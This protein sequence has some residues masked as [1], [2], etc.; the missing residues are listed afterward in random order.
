[1]I[2]PVT[3]RN[4]ATPRD[5]DIRLKRLHLDQ[6][7]VDR[8]FITD[9]LTNDKDASIARTIIT[10]GRNLDLTVIA[11]GVETN[12]QREFLEKQECHVYQGFLSSPAL[13][14]SQ[15]ETFIEASIAKE[16]TRTVKTSA[17]SVG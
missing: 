14:F 3:S 4:V 13:N 16:K 15:F 7:K 17:A 9:L 1:M 8:A 5:G 6:L 10:L 2:K 11:D 12:G